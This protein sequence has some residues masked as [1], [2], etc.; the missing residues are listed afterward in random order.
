MGM[1]EDIRDI[2]QNLCKWKG[3]A[4]IEGKVAPGPHPSAIINT[5]EEF[6]IQ[7]HGISKREKRIMIYER[8]ANLKYKYGNQHFRATGYYASTWL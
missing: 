2:V 1:R 6:N 3:V 8:H 5:A 4:I 7:L